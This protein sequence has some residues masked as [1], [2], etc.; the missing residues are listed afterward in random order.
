VIERLE[1]KIKSMK[2]GEVVGV[3]L[4]DN[5]RAASKAVL[6]TQKSDNGFS[7]Q[8]LKNAGFKNS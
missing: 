5:P 3:G 2:P 7:T 1:A 4:D 6:K 8:F